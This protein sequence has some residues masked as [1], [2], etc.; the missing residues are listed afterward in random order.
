MT[1]TA[2][3]ARV[4]ALIK[5]KKSDSALMTLQHYLTPYGP[6]APWHYTPSTGVMAMPDDSMWPEIHEGDA[7]ALD[8][9]VEPLR[10]DVVVV[11]DR[12]GGLWIRKYRP[13]LRGKFDCPAGNADHATLHCE[14][15]GPL[16]ILAVLVGHWR[17]RRARVH[18]V[19]PQPYHNTPT[20]HPTRKTAKQTSKAKEAA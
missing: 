9:T 19:P 5:L 1:S 13:L 6:G 4:P 15:D 11:A 3:E 16:V 8:H 7:I 14:E 12:F 2:T 10:G 18:D 17:G 20:A